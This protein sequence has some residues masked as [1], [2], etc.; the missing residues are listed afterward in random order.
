MKGL[1]CR[2]RGLSGL[3]P[4]PFRR[5]PSFSVSD[6]PSPRDTRSSTFPWPPLPTGVCLGVSSAGSLSFDASVRDAPEWSEVLCRGHF[7]NNAGAGVAA[8]TAIHLFS[9]GA[10]LIAAWRAPVRRRR[11]SPPPTMTTTRRQM[12][13]TC[14]FTS[15]HDFQNFSWL[16]MMRRRLR[17]SQESPERQGHRAHED[18]ATRGC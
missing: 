9:R 17:V 5:P 10:S 16:T 13:R 8:G 12:Q 6:A 7:C 15:A 1:T 3:P 11:A 18:I 14:C 2:A 4:P